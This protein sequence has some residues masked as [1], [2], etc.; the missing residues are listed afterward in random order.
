MR[1]PSKVLTAAPPSE[2]R[3]ERPTARA[4]HLAH[5]RSPSL[6]SANCWFGAASTPLE[7]TDVNTD[8]AA[9][10]PETVPATTWT[11]S[12]SLT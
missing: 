11:L 4:G 10:V 1:F 12:P 5:T 8:P 6:L 7:V 3:L 2:V 9:A